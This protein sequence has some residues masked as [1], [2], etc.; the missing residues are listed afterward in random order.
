[1]ALRLANMTT[2][3]S[4]LPPFVNHLD[5]ANMTDDLRRGWSQAFFVARVLAPAYPNPLD[6]ISSIPRHIQFFVSIQ[7]L[8]WP[9]QERA[10]LQR[11]N[12]VLNRTWTLQELYN[13]TGQVAA[14]FAQCA[15][16]LNGFQA[17]NNGTCDRCPPNC[18]E[19]SA[20]SCSVCREGFFESGGVCNPCTPPCATCDTSATSCTRCNPP[21]SLVS[22]TC[23]QCAEPCATCSAANVSSCTTCKRPFSLTA[24]SGTCFRCNQ[25]LCV[26]CQPGNASICLECRFGA[27]LVDGRCQFCPANCSSCSSGSPPTCFEC[28][29]G[30]K[31]VALGNNTL[32]LP[33]GP[34]CIRCSDESCLECQPGTFLNADTGRCQ[35][36]K[37]GCKECTSLEVCT[38]S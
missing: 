6:L 17:G 38:L 34:G 36:C 1:M 26:E 2:N 21:L 23:I 15:N 3:I 24:D 5:F 14:G 18:L 29:S 28:L 13:R 20:G 22:S 10:I 16:C 12:T 25:D 37:Q 7:S 9:N 32:C 11:I 31:L 35:R 27:T 8:S 4:S 19:C 30:Y 33:C